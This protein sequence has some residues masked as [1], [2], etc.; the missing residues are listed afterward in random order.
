MAWK[1]ILTENDIG[2]G[3]PNLGHSHEIGLQPEDFNGSPVS[4]SYD[5]S[6]YARATV[7][8]ED[9]L[10]ATDEQDLVGGEILAL[11]DG[12]LWSKTNA[13]TAGSTATKLLGVYVGTD[14]AYVKT[15]LEGFVALPETSIDPSTVGSLEPGDLMYLSET[16][17]TIT[18][19]PSQITGRAV[20][21]VGYCLTYYPGTGGIFWFKPEN[22][23][24]EIAN[25]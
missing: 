17:G 7:I 4:L 16:Q 18:Q 6:E 2:N 1:K 14:G 24:L 3:I 11:T 15:V 23:W 21:T 9:A 13:V 22:L 12:T 5:G 10:F 25:P 20:R 8:T 19:T